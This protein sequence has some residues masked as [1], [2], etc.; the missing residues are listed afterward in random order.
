MGLLVDREWKWCNSEKYERA[1]RD[2]RLSEDVTVDEGALGTWLLVRRGPVTQA[3]LNIVHEHQLDGYTLGEEVSMREKILEGPPPKL[4]TLHVKKPADLSFVTQLARLERLH[5]ELSNEVPLDLSSLS[6]LKILILGDQCRGVSGHFDLKNLTEF[7]AEQ[8]TPGLIGALSGHA[9]LEGLDLRYSKV[10]DISALG[11]LKNL[12]FL[13]IAHMRGVTDFSWIADCTKL[14]ELW[15]EYNGP[16]E[17]T[18]F[19]RALKNLKVL[20]MQNVTS[21]SIFA[22]IAGLPH[23]AD[24]VVQAQEKRLTPPTPS[25]LKPLQGHPS[26]KRIIALGPWHVDSVLPLRECPNLTTINIRGSGSKIEDD[27]IEPL[28]GMPSILSITVPGRKC[29]DRDL[30]RPSGISS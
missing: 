28:K 6:S 16:I 9:T 13:N 27:T 17:D 10:K 3:C 19:L 11:N 5:L 24:V 4:L 7:K 15:L 21:A 26:L 18:T 30:E 20:K 22:D 12:R 23:I 1:N 8:L 25:S 2:R 29:W 14:E